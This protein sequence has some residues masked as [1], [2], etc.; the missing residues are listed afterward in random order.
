[1][2]I[3][4]EIAVKIYGDDLDTLRN[5]AESLQDRL[6]PIAGL[7]DLQVEKQNRIPQLRVEADH[8]RARLYGVSPAVL[9]RALEGM[10]NGRT[11]SQ[12]VTEG[13]RRFDV[14][15][16]LSD[17]DRSTTGL[18]DLLVETPSGHVPLHLVARIDETDGPNQILRENGQRRIAVYANTDGM[19]DRAQIVADIRDVLAATAWPQGYRTT[20]EGAYQAYEDAALMEEA[21][22]LCAR[23]ALAPTAG[24]ALIKRALDQ[25]WDN[26]LDA[27]LDLERDFQREASLNPDYAEGVRAFMEKRAPRFAGRS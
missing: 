12:V 8:E 27:Q 22:K 11:V 7:A 4:A 14:V 2:R 16:R 10:S 5:L 6:V 21:H 13:N 1:V 15:I 20:L 17:M 18:G 23:F 25:S 26:S 3:R 24:L 19:R 9:T